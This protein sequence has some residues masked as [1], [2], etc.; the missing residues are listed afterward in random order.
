[1]FKL[2]DDRRSVGKSILMSG[3]LFGP[4]TNFSPFLELFLD[5][6]WF[7]DVGR[8]LWREVGSVVLSWVQFIDLIFETHP[9]WMSLY[10]Y[11]QEQGSPVVYCLLDVYFIAF[12]K[13][14]KCLKWKNS[15]RKL[16]WI[17]AQWRNYMRIE[18]SHTMN[19]HTYLSSFICL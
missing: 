16:N 1:M 6:F 19:Q 4:A 12:Y 2:Y 15:S 5:D 11:H 17:L 18:L 13:I 7:N 9:T 8:L 3:T 10:L 14:L